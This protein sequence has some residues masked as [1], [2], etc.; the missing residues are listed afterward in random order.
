M[1]NKGA[2]LKFMYNKELSWYRATNK[3]PNI[4]PF[5]LCDLRAI[6]ACAAAIHSSV[7]GSPIITCQ[8]VSKIKY[9]IHNINSHCL[10]L[11]KTAEL[12]DI[13]CCRIYWKYRIIIEL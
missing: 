5:V 9:M 7:L 6:I 2:L 10:C 12:M 1:I 3:S 13:L 8:C 11:F 4:T